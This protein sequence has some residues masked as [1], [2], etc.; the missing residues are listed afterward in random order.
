MYSLLI[1]VI[2]FHIRFFLFFDNTFMRKKT[3]VPAFTLIEVL[4][5]IAIISILL[6][7]VTNIDFS[8]LSQKQKIDI[9]VTG[10]VNIIEETR[11]NALVWR[12]IDASNISPNSWSIEVENTSS[13]WSLTSRYMSGTLVDYNAWSASDGFSIYDLR[14]QRL[15]NSIGS[16][17]GP[18]TITFTWSQWSISWC[19][20]AQYKKLFFSYWL[21]PIWRNITIN[22]LTWVIE[23]D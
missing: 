9:G 21:A 4:V 6:L 12:S 23:I 22:T 11:N 14:C 18:F 3:F 15:D 1:R 20:D 7:W 17:S 2:C 19:S 13:S 10:I 5:A 16:N 8:R